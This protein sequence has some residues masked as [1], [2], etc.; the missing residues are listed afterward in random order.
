MRISDLANRDGKA[1]SNQSWRSETD[2]GRHYIYHYST[3]M[4]SYDVMPS[5][6]E[7]FEWDQDMDTVYGSLGHLSVSDQQGMNIL[8]RTLGMPF[9]FVRARNDYGI[10]STDPDVVV[11]PFAKWMVA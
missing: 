11:F 6:T 8:F 3:L 2:N 7:Y 10:Y 9:Y 1:G 5:I 4:L